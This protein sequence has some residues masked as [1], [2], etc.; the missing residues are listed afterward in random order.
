M[1]GADRPRAS[2]AGG[3]DAARAKSGQAE[4]GGAVII[5]I[6]PGTTESAFVALQTRTCTKCAACLPFDKFGKA[7]KGK[8]GLQSI[9]KKCC[10]EHYYVPKKSEIMHRHR[11]RRATPEGKE[12][13]K[14]WRN[15]Y[16]RVHR[17][18]RMLIEARYRAAKR[19]FEFTITLND[20]SI[21][22]RCPILGIPISCLAESRADGSPSIER[23]DNSL[24]YVKGNVIIVSWRANRIKSDA[25]LD[26]LSKILEY[27]RNLQAST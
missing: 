15:N 6:D 9:C 17:L 3:Q 4:E 12:N 26:E 14:S 1:H 7:K 20:L 23:I 16:R 18:K 22:D 21:P 27:Y 10:R 19:G 11:L 5:A 13:E 25:T 24:G 8:Y 2:G